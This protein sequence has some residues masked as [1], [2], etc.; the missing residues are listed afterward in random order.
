MALQD[1]LRMATYDP[2]SAIQHFRFEEVNNTTIQN[3]C[4][5]INNYCGK[6]IDV[7]AG[8]EKEGDR[9]IIWDR[10]KRWNQRWIFQKV[11]S[12]HLIKSVMN[13][14]C[15]DI[16]GESRDNGAKIVQWPQTGGTNQLWLIQPAGEDLFKI[17]SYHEPSLCLALRKQEGS[18]GTYL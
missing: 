12:V 6:A 3:S 17:W 7:P 4:L 8:S 16:A 1:S 15:L 9:I 14:L 10:N 11:G 13:G 18:D 2:N 5:I